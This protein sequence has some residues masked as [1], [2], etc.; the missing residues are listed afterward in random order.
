MSGRGRGQPGGSGPSTSCQTTQIVRPCIRYGRLD[1]SISRDCVAVGRQGSASCRRL[2][3]A[4]RLARGAGSGDRSAWCRWWAC[5]ARE[6]TRRRRCGRR[7]SIHLARNGQRPGLARGAHRS[8]V[9][10]R[11]RPPGSDGPVGLRRTRRH[12][13]RS[14]LVGP[15][16][17]QPGRTRSDQAV[18][19]AL[20]ADTCPS[21][22]GNCL[23]RQK[24]G[25]KT[26][27][28]DGS[29]N[30]QCRDQ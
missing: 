19:S 13:A 15:S 8:R 28:E 16:R 3:F 25:C 6:A 7:Q 5:V 23:H 9:G 18:A 26:P 21:C 4:R 17:P 10:V 29:E 20:S 12:V 11:S 14:A 22:V 30:H 2:V 24:C 1:V 27:S